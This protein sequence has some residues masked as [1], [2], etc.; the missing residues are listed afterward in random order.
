[1]L[2]MK[3]WSIRILGVLL[4]MGSFGGGFLAGA[5]YGKLIGWVTFIVLASVGILLHA[6][7]DKIR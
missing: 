1:M 7:A 4:F 2:P 6:R 3:Y 5:T